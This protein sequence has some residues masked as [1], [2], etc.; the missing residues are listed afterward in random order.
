MN[1]AVFV[2]KMNSSIL[3]EAY[4]INCG[5][6]NLKCGSN[7][8]YHTHG[9]KQ[10]NRAESG[11]KLLIFGNFSEKHEYLATRGASSEISSE[12]SSP[13]H[14]GSNDVSLKLWAHQDKKSI[15]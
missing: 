4:R 13:G 15:L 1:K 12:T 6:T 3:T 7:D 11:V 8:T 9:T 10:P 5:P 14:C 2:S